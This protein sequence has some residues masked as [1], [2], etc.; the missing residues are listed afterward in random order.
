MGTFDSVYQ[1]K[2]RQL[3]EENR[4]LKQIL[5]EANE[6]TPTDR[7]MGNSS[8]IREPTYTEMSAKEIFQQGAN[9]AMHGITTPPHFFNNR[10]F[11]RGFYSVLTAGMT[12]GIGE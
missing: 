7:V 4:K 5:S 10:H 11:A 3:Q 8:F 9:H 6:E 1:Q 12:A 2:I